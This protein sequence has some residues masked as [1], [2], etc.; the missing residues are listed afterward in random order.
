MP[1]SAE[2]ASPAWPRTL[3]PGPGRRA[4]RQQGG[5]TGGKGYRMS[6]GA[7]RVNETR[8]ARPQSCCGARPARPWT[9]RGNRR[10]RSCRRQAIQCLPMSMEPASWRQAYTAV[11]RW[12]LAVGRWPLAVG[13][14]PLANYT[15]TD[16]RPMSSSGLPHT[17]PKFRCRKPPAVN[18]RGSHP[19]RHPKWPPG[20][21]RRCALVSDSEF[22]SVA[23]QTAVSLE[24]AGLPVRDSSRR[25][26]S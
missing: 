4:W 16:R 1:G 25:S 15:R 6:P 11:G 20:K 26:V 12:P 9:G 5:R 3:P 14:W 7:A 13:R 21:P 24:R 18:R 10:E 8:R 19:W 22:A 23:S 2:S 17:C